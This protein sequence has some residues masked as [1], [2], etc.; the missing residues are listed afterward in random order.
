MLCAVIGGG[1]AEHMALTGG[2][3]HALVGIAAWLGPRGI[4]ELVGQV[5]AARSGAASNKEDV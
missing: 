5:V 2:A 4:E 3:A 1:V